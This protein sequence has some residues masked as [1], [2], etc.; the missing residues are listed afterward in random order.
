MSTMMWLHAIVRCK[1]YGLKFLLCNVWL[2]TIAAFWLSVF[3]PYVCTSQFDVTRHNGIWIFTL[4]FSQNL[5]FTG[6]A[7]EQHERPGWWPGR[8]N[9][10]GVGRPRTE[11]SCSHLARSSRSR[12]SGIPLR[13]T[14]DPA[15]KNL[16]LSLSRDIR[17]VFQDLLDVQGGNNKDLF[18]KCLNILKL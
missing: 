12:P 7:V 14:R 18:G 4:F 15:Q 1:R 17:R 9:L 8:P 10:E 13:R 2:S 16:L 3:F 5:M 6:E 11:K